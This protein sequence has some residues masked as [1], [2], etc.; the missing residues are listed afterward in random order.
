MYCGK[1]GTRI[2]EQ[3][4]FCYNCGTEI[5]YYIDCVPEPKSKVTVALLAL[6]LGV[7]GAH[8]F[9]LGKHENACAQLFFSVTGLFFIAVSYLIVSWG[10]VLLYLGIGLA[11]IGIPISVIWVL[12]EFIL[13]IS[14]VRSMTPEKKE[15]DF[16][17]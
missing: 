5:N 1:C 4:A 8:N 3:D 11:V 16:Y 7:L 12:I 14:G 9:Y 2:A 13:I 15:E 17:D 6:F 10:G